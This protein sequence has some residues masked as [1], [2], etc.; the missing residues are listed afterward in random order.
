MFFGVGVIIVFSSQVLEE[1]FHCH[2]TNCHK[3]S[4]L[5]IYYFTVSVGQKSGGGMAGFSAQGRTRLKSR[6]PPVC[7]SFWSFE[8]SLKLGWLL[9]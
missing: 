1:C 5:S 7:I 3:L 6:S 9:A 4:G 8:S 2:A